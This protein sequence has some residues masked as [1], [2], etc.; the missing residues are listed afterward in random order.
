[1]RGRPRQGLVGESRVDHA[2]P[3]CAVAFDISLGTCLTQSRSA[4]GPFRA[5]MLTLSHCSTSSSENRCLLEVLCM[6]FWSTTPSIVEIHGSLGTYCFN[7]SP[8]G[9]VGCCVTHAMCSPACGETYGDGSGCPTEGK[10][11]DHGT[12][13]GSYNATAARTSRRQS[14]VCSILVIV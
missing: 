10:H 12:V 8:A 7:S 14:T 3:H 4:C 5:G 11:S 6:G 2:A 1:M 13:I 9:R